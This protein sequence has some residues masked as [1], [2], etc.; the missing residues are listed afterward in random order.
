MNQ[1]FL[2]HNNSS[3]I[4]NVHTHLLAT[5]LFLLDKQD[6]IQNIP[7]FGRYRFVYLV[8]PVLHSRSRPSGGRKRHNGFQTEQDV[9][10]G[11]KQTP[12]TD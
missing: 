10:E 11:C 1:D 7:F 2:K 6:T 3:N 5:T 12:A 8:T 4:H 9:T